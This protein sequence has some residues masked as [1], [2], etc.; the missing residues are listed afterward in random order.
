MQTTYK[1]EPAAGSSTPKRINAARSSSFLPEGA[2][3]LGVET[4]AERGEAGGIGVE[5]RDCA[6][7]GATPI[8]RALGR[9][10]IS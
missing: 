5:H 9:F 8:G 3:I 2:H 7:I 1:S 10:G 4:L 6:A